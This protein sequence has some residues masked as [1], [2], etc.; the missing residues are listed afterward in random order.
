MVCAMQRDLPAFVSN[1]WSLNKNLLWCPL[2]WLAILYILLNL[3]LI[4][5]QCDV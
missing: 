1:C 4:P 3:D 2:K 5:M